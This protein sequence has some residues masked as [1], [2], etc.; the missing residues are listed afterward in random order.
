MVRNN[1]GWEIT[2]AGADA[3]RFRY[4]IDVDPGGSVPSWIV[5]MAN[6]SQVPSVIAA[7]EDEAQ[8]LA[9]RRARNAARP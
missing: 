8:K 1:G 6:K 3:S 5:N 2:P 4:H 9:V 7:V